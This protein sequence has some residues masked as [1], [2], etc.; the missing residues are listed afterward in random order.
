MTDFST[1]QS[2]EVLRK[3]IEQIVDEKLNQKL[4]FFQNELLGLQKTVQKIQKA[5]PKDQVSILVS[6]H[7]L[8]NLLPAFIVATGAASFGMEVSMFFTLWGITAL[9]TKNI[10]TG[11]SIAEKMLTVM[12]PSD[13]NDRGI[14]RLNMMGM[15]KMMMKGMMK[16][17]NV[18]T[19]PEL[20]ELAGELGVKMTACQMTMGIMGISREE[21]RTDI[22]YGGVAAYIEDASESKITLFI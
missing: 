11:K 20:I 4:L 10:F 15:G 14:S 22:G 1:L 7:E 12:L 21:L 2:D 8:D 18:A 13:A 17:E 5:M 9:K 19:L 16:A 3:Y 6:S